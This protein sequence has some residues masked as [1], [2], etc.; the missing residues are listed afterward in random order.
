MNNM[1]IQREAIIE[2]VG[3]QYEGRTLNHQSLFLRQELTL[4]HLRENSHDNDEVLLLTKD[5]KELG[6]LPKEYSS[7]YAPAIDT[8]KYKFT[9]EI[10]KAVPDPVRPILIIKV[11][12][13]LA[14][15]NETEIES[16]IIDFIQNIVNGH[17]LRTKEYLRFICSE[18][19]NVDE[20]LASLD[21]ARLIQKLILCSNDIIDSHAIKPNTDKY[22]PLTKD[23]LINKLS[24]LKTDISNVLKQIQAA[25]NESLDID[26][27]EEYHRVQSNIRERRKKFRQYDELF[28]SLLDAVVSYNNISE[29]SE[30]PDSKVIGNELDNSAH[31]MDSVMT[32]SEHDATKSV[33]TAITK[34]E[35][36]NIISNSSQFTEQ[37]FFE[38]LVS[39]GGVSESTAKQYISNIHSIEKLYQTL[40]GVRNNLL[41]TKSADNARAMIESLIVTDEYIDAN[42]RRHNSFGISLAK[43]AQF[44][45]I[46]I[47]GLKSSI[48]K[49]NY[50][51]PVISAPFVVK[52]VDFDNPHNCTYYK[53]CSLIFNEFKYVV[54]SWRELYTKFLTLLYT[55]NTYSE[56]IN[57]L[58][59]KSLYGHRIDFADKELSHYLRRP[60]IVSTNFFAEGNLSA[61]DIIKRI[62]CLMELCSIS[63]DSIVIEYN[64]QEKNFEQIE[65]IDT[66]ADR[67]E[68]L[69]VSD[70]KDENV[71]TAIVADKPDKSA[72]NIIAEQP[73]TKST[74]DEEEK[75]ER[76][77]FVEWLINNMGLASATAK[78]YYSSVKT[79]ERIAREQKL[80]SQRLFD[81]D[82]YDEA[83]ET[84]RGLLQCDAFVKMNST[85][86][87]SLTAGVRKLLVY[88]DATKPHQEHIEQITNEAPI[89]EDTPSIVAFA[90][91]TTKPFVL[92][93]AVIEILSSDAPEITKHK[94]YKNGITSKSL[95]D[96]LKEYY[97]KTIGLFE[98]SKLLMLDRTFQSV[99]KGCYIV[100]EAAIPHS[101]P[102]SEFVPKD[103]PV[104]LVAEPVPTPVHVNTHDVPTVARPVKT[105]P[106]PMST[107][108]QTDIHE[109]TVADDTLDTKSE[110]ELTIEPIIAVIREN[111]DNLQYEEGFGAY[112]VK[113]LLSQKGYTNLVE[114]EI[115]AL[116]SG[117]SQLREIEDGYYTLAKVGDTTETTIEASDSADNSTEYVAAEVVESPISTSVP[118]EPQQVDTDARRIVLRLNGNVIRAYDYSDALSKVCEFSINY[119]PF[120]MARIAGQ[121][122]IL[123]GKKVF[124][125]KSV[126]ID[127]YNN[128]SNGLQIITIATLSDLQ[129][130]T[131]AVQK[132][133]QIDDDMIDIISQ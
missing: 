79:S 54:G 5:G 16:D 125:R 81:A 49:K 83:S 128:L 25:Y 18:T 82:S 51:S 6:S 103:E 89:V 101:E 86:H 31:E 60:I 61:I 70:A 97:G 118:N 120:R 43:F 8:D 113:T 112:E 99:G 91:D 111:Y 90:P 119:K 132:Y 76:N 72:T 110:N 33:P 55:D 44:A 64:T 39:D 96:L 95:R 32:V 114:G 124:Y 48:D 59:G 7:L 41:G 28:S 131:A 40:F 117:C 36:N 116:M 127:G 100:N 65:L 102:E 75:I 45:D 46:S 24:E 78:S 3:T 62:K 42:E 56:T 88:L 29:Q 77:D 12:S 50:Q 63:D 93:D 23:S 27:E 66:D 122:I 26:D 57:G 30:L 69:S 71:D 52:T 108:T 104:K 98:I 21:K 121:D 9:I 106:E 38:W 94:E 22:T 47:D 92:K 85:A 126:P 80:K 109:E 58:I 68:Q 35:S 15:H 1:E 74:N 84:F 19:V 34:P 10:V 129:T 67:F 37:A 11:I 13:E 73:E 4:K 105:M 53:P 87:N 20:L 115:E 133:C 17:S 2:I 123:N 14:S 130:I 107:A